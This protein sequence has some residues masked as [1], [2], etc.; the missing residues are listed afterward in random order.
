MNNYKKI[1]TSFLA[2]AVK[3]IEEG[4]LIP[5]HIETQISHVFLYPNTVYKICKRDNLFFNQYFRDLSDTEERKRFYKADFFENNYFSPEVYL[6]VYGVNVSESDVVITDDIDDAMDV[7]MKMRRIDLNCNLSELLHERILTEEDFRRMGYQQTKAVDLYP[8]QPKTS[9]SYYDIF[10]RRLDDLR[11]W[12]YSAPDYF[13]KETTDKIITI[14][15]NYLEKEKDEFL[16]FDRSKYVISLDNH[17]DN[18]F[19]QNGKMFFLDIYPPKE[20]WMIVSPWTNIYRPATDIL[21]LMNE[22]CARAFIEGYKDY[23]GG[24][25]ESH[26]LFYFIYSASIQAISLYNLSGNSSIKLEDANLYK[27]YILE[28]IEKI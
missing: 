11:D 4:G 10:Q 2:G 9:E 28:N 1:I 24:L 23:Y 5:E 26:E 22:D 15:R 17:S 25:D 6:N 20:D 18:I 3:G 7:V 14:L 8:Y 13:P 27:K 12:M 16:Y 19:Y 21:I